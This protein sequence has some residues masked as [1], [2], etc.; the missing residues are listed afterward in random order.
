[1]KENIQTKSGLSLNPIG[2]IQDLLTGTAFQ[3]D[4][5][6]QGHLKSLG[7]LKCVKKKNAGMATTCLPSPYGRAYEWP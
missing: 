3:E 2:S 7:E 1:M 5:D 4:T 6:A